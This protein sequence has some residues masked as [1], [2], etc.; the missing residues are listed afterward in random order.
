MSTKEPRPERVGTCAKIFILFARVPVA[1]ECT[2]HCQVWGI[3]IGGSVC[4]AF[5]PDCAVVFI[6]IGARSASWMILERFQEAH[7]WQTAP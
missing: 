2:K 5:T 7:T 6:I 1:T 4:R 3:C